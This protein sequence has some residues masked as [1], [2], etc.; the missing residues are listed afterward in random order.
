[1]TK[2]AKF[3]ESGKRKAQ[4][5]LWS[6]AK[7]TFKVTAQ[8]KEG[9]YTWSQRRRGQEK[10]LE[11]NDGSMESRDGEGHLARGELARKRVCVD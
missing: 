5:Q 4:G 2:R 8:M 11:G 6:W 3:T 9:N 1:M 10:E 7:N